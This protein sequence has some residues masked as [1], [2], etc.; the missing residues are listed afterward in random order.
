MLFSRS[1]RYLGLFLAFAIVLGCVI[2]NPEDVSADAGIQ[3]GKTYT[4]AKTDYDYQFEDYCAAFAFTPEKS[5]YYMI[6]GTLIVEPFYFEDFGLHNM[7]AY[8]YKWVEPEY[9]LES[10]GLS[11]MYDDEYNQVF[12]LEEGQQYYLIHFKDDGYEN[13]EGQFCVREVKNFIN[14]SVERGCSAIRGSTFTPCIFMDASIDYTSVSYVWYENNRNIIQTDYDVTA[15]AVELNTDDYLSDQ[16]FE[17]GWDCYPVYCQVSFSYEGYRYYRWIN[18]IPVTPCENVLATGSWAQEVGLPYGYVVNNDTSGMVFTVNAWTLAPDATISYQWY[19]S[20]DYGETYEIL[21]GETD[22]QLSLDVLDEPVIY[23]IDNDS[24]CYLARTVR[25]VVTFEDGTNV[26]NRS[27]FFEVQYGIEN[28]FIGNTS[29][30]ANYGDTITFPVSGCFIEPFKDEG[31]EYWYQWIGNVYDTDGSTYEYQFGTMNTVSIDT[32]MLETHQ[33]SEGMYSDISCTCYVYHNGKFYD[34]EV[35]IQY[36]FRIYYKNDTK[37][38]TSGIAIN[39]TNFPDAV[40][41]QYVSENIDVNNTG[42]LSAEEIEGVRKIDVSGKNINDLTGINY[43]GNLRLLYCADN[44]LASLDISGLDNLLVL[45]ADGNG[46]TSIDFGDNSA[47]K[48]VYLNDNNLTSIN[49]DGAPYLSFAY[50]Y[51]PQAMISGDYKYYGLFNCYTMVKYDMVSG[52]MLDLQTTVENC[53]PLDPT[54][55]KLKIVKDPENAEGIVGDTAKIGV[56]CRGDNITY[57]WQ[58][59]NVGSNT[60]FNSSGLSAKTDTL[61]FTVSANANG[62]KFRCIVSDGTDTITSGVATFTVI[63]GI[64]ITRQPENYIGLEGTTAKF[65][66]VAEGDDLTYQW[67]LKKGSKWADLTT[68]GATTS[69][70][71][72]KADASKNG[73]IYRC[74]ITDSHD[75][76]AITDEVSITIKE[77]SITINT[78]PKD[79]SGPEGSTA[80]FS[81]AAEGEGLTYQWQLKKGSKW[82]DL[83]T[84][85]ATTA[86]LSVKVDGAKNGKIYRCLI[87]NVDGE[88]LAT[89]E[90]SITVK[91]P[92]IVISTQPKNY[93][94]PEGNTAKFNVVAEGE[95]LTYQWQ[96]KKGSKWAD[97]TSG[98][99]T[100]ST[101]SIKVDSSKNG[102][103]YRCLITN[104]DG[105]ELATQE[106]SITIKEP[107]ITI[108]KQPNDV[109]GSVGIKAIFEVEAEGEG[110]TYQWQLKKGSSWADLTSGGATTTKMTVKVDAGK[111]GKTYRCLITN[112]AGEQLA[113][114]EVQI[115]EM[116]DHTDPFEDLNEPSQQ[117][118]VSGEDPSE[119]PVVPV[120]DPVQPNNS[121]QKID[122]VDATASEQE[123][124]NAPVE[125]PAPEP[126]SETSV[127]NEPVAGSE[128]AETIG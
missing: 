124:A 116:K 26:V 87:T 63:K 11:K 40:F 104:V 49:L 82:A 105:E 85:G 59:Q 125:V 93:I 23:E 102:K 28:D 70:M 92:D 74:V 100:T 77:P 5:A 107:D 50:Q 84:G 68:G 21:P 67:Q 9:F 101:L 39:S 54:P 27:C 38:D 7:I 66:V 55:I 37:P 35:P 36:E 52:L 120:P 98:G 41:R 12:Y 94:G 42:Y 118:A 83:T 20:D 46:L 89:N 110:L 73:K 16:D 57:Q 91:E 45:Q 111:F 22:Y 115:V 114:N 61:E 18:D 113:T 31:Y 8:G 75:R 108:V 51:G 58:Y 117:S 69:T 103:I 17:N 25:C 62:R 99:A 53:V 65:S 47:L 2:F 95:G 13:N 43:F 14:F 19:F 4:I 34:R 60:W 80:K 33:D 48:T 71:T 90:V 32:S 29:F 1:K 76:T 112:A 30:A 86:T 56:G 3:L 126:V 128:S 97:L 127:V 106:A 10:F 81:V 109:W 44:N 6:T 72:L 24:W 96:L 121:V 78:Q 64:S 119:S 122:T 15:S 88:E 123:Q 79:F